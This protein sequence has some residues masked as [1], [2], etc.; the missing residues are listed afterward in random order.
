MISKA[1]AHLGI[2]P[3]NQFFKDGGVLAYTV[4]A[5]KDGDGTYA[6]VRL[7]LGVTADMVASQ[8]PKLAANLG[9]AALETWPTKGDE[10]GILDLWVADKGTLNGGAGDWPLLHDGQVDLFKGVPFG[11]SQRGL[12]INAPLIGANWL[13]GGRPGQGK[14]AC[15]RT[16][17]LGAALDPTAELWVYVMGEAPD[18]EP[19]AP[20]LMRYRMGM[21][22]AVAE[23]ALQALSDLL[24]EMERRGRVLGQ[25]PVGRPKCRA[26]WPTTAVSACTRSCARST[27]ATNC[28]NIPSTA[29]K[30]L[31]WQSG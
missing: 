18:F 30:P 17:L 22:D 31:R 8:R 16:I 10:D 12:V 4:P 20:R 15:L 24:D 2:S 27:N 9:R 14:S 7:P 13:I 11:L 6:Q 5:R 28:S 1:L 23:A 3:L 26:D 29:N 21:D 25:Q 19:F